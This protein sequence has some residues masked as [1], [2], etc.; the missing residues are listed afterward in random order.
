MNTKLTV[1]EMAEATGLSRDTLRFYEK[2]GLIDNI[3]R[4]ANGHRRYSQQDVTWVEFLIRLRTTGMSI[5]QMQ[6]YSDLRRQGDATLTARRQLLE[7]HQAD[8]ENHIREYEQL[9]KFIGDKIETY[10][11]MEETQHARRNE[12]R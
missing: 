8:V 12:V 1:Q 4:A 5:R 7:A 6:H 10:R 9:L 2:I 11:Q 3:E